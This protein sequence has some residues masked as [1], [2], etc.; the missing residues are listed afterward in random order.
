MPVRRGLRFVRHALGAI[1]FSTIV[2]GTGVSTAEDTSNLKTDLLMSPDFRV[3]VGAALALGRTRPPDARFVL[4][5]ALDDAHP[6]VRAAAAAA[7]A[8]VDDDGAVPTL[9]KHL[10]SESSGAVKSQLKSSIDQLSRRKIVGSIESARFV[11]QLGNMTNATNVR[12]DQ[13]GTIM[14][15]AARSRASG[16]K[17]VLVVDNGDATT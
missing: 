8:Q 5:R 2:C 4:E 12:G 7:L 10:A 3:R 6:A 9:Q 13:L 1:V 11:V 17:G 14:R 16:L 15:D